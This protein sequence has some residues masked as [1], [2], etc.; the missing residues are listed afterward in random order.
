MNIK[1][2][3]I[4]CSLAFFVSVSAQGRALVVVLLDYSDDLS[5]HSS[6]FS[7]YKDNFLRGRITEVPNLSMGEIAY[8]VATGPPPH[9]SPRSPIWTSLQ[10]HNFNAM[11][12]GW[13]DNDSYLRSYPQIRLARPNNLMTA[14]QDSL[15]QI[16]INASNL[17]MIFLDNHNMVVY[18]YILYFFVR[19][20][21]L[22]LIY[23]LE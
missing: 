17:S 16:R 19:A 23:L 10:R 11:S 22:N 21:N 2:Q 4:L 3:L 13:P 5:K 9:G 14:I 7:S 18:Q 15:T 20:I 8:L 12:Y 1:I 6:K